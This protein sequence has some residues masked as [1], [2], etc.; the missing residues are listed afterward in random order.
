MSKLVLNLDVKYFKVFFIGF[1]GKL[2]DF[3]DIYSI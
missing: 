3:T 1:S 2:L